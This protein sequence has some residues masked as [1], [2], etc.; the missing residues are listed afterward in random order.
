MDNHIISSL[1]K[2][3]KPDASFLKDKECL[4]C[5]ETFDLESN[6]NIVKLPCNCSNSAYHILC[7]VNLL[8]SGENKNFCPHCKTNYEIHLHVEM[9]IQVSN[10]QVLPYIVIN[11]NHQVSNSSDDS[12]ILICHIFSNSIMN[13]INIC[14]SKLSIEYE[15]IEELQVLMLFYVGKLFFNYCI[16]MYSKGNIEKTE[17]SL[18]CSYVFQTVLFGLLVYL[19]T[20]INNDYK[21]IIL[22]FNNILF[23][24]LDLSFRLKKECKIRNT[25]NMLR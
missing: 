22:L 5:L 24:S 23:S 10:N 13:F 9:Q 15:N 7:I 25:V 6:N 17:I 1:Q 2:F 12:N 4:I 8:H 20:K 21:S 19:L 3:E 14:L 18:I 16:L 11:I